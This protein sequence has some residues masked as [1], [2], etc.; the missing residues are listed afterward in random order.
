[1]ILLLLIILFD[2]LARTR[3]ADR[4]GAARSVLIAL[5]DYAAGIG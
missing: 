1:V 5:G 3:L 4:P 2:R